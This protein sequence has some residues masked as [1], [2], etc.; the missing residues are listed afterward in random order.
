[1][2]KLII[3]LAVVGIAAISFFI[4]DY[5]RQGDDQGTITI[6]LVDQIGD[7]ISSQTHDFDEDDTLFDILSE[8]YDIQC[9]DMQYRPTTCQDSVLMEHVILTIDD[10]ETDWFN[11]YIAIYVNDQYS[12]YGISDIPLEDDAVYRFQHDT[13]EGAF[14]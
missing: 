9:A 13:V 1:M 14:E 2:K 3:T 10:I 6:V 7:T 8:H 4:S 11:T 12:S 5:L